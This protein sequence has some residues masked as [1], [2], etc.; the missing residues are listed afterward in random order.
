M[1]EVI[2]YRNYAE[3]KQELDTELKRPR[4]DLSVSDIC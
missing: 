3:Y 1:N 4:R 2:E